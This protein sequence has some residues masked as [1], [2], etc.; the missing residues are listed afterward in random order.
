MGCLVNREGGGQE[1]ARGWAALW[2]ELPADLLKPR[3]AASFRAN[4]GL[5]PMGS[6]S[7]TLCRRLFRSPLVAEDLLV[8]GELLHLARPLLYCLLL[9]K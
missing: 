1:G 6:A 5:Q 8:A 2:P 4:E 7:A 3:Y 9:R